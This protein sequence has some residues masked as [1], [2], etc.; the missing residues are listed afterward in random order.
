MA[1]VKSE[2]HLLRPAGVEEQSVHPL[3]S[4]FGPLPSAQVV[5]AEAVQTLHPV[6]QSVQTLSAAY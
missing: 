5:Q 1:V 3:S 4:A 2:A 6:P